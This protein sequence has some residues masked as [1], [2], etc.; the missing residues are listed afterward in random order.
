M[1][2]YKFLSFIAILGLLITTN[3][4]AQSSSE[5]AQLIIVEQQRILLKIAIAEENYFAENNEYT[6]DYEK[7]KEIGLELVP[8]FEYGPITVFTE[9]FSKIPCYRFSIAHSS[10]SIIQ[11]YDS[12]LKDRM[13]IVQV[14]P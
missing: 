4:H 10:Q 14:L 6:D 3:L 8:D 9:Y 7:L 12:S 5:T 13:F 11:L 2:I 1:K